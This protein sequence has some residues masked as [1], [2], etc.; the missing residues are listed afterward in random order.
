MRYIVYLAGIAAALV[1]GLFTVNSLSPETLAVMVGLVFGVAASIPTA[2]LVYVSIRRNDEYRP[3]RDDY[4]PA[5]QPP[6]VMI[7]PPERRQTFELPPVR[8]W[9]IVDM[10][11]TTDQENIDLS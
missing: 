11:W 10:P 3:R 4:Q 8:E 6:V 7:A 2:L 5:P 9:Q 1:F